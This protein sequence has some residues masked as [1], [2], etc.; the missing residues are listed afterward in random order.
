MGL[1]V[2]QKSDSYRLWL[3]CTKSQ[4][5]SL[6]RELIES[7]EVL[8]KKGVFHSCPKRSGQCQGWSKQIERLFRSEVEWQQ[9]P[10]GSRL[11]WCSLST[12]FIHE[13]PFFII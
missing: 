4:S 11:H 8:Y 12:Q 3:C 10:N 9:C 1:F 7:A 2:G 5:R 13:F 6:S